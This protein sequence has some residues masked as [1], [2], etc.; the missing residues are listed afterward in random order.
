MPLHRARHWVL[1]LMFPLFEGVEWLQRLRLLPTL[2][3]LP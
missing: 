3:R 1:A 2:L